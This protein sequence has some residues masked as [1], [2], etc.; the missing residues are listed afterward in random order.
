MLPPAY[1]KTFLTPV[2]SIFTKFQDSEFILYVWG[3]LSGLNATPGHIS[4]HIFAI[5]EAILHKIKENNVH[6]HNHF[7]C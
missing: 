4:G 1:S 3:G 2:I 6:I 7:H 5:S